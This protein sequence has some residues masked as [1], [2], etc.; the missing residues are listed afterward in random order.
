[1]A[2]FRK[3]DEPTAAAAAGSS[4]AAARSSKHPQRAS[5]PIKESDGRKAANKVGR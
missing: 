2:K 4:A 5:K 3:L 1:M